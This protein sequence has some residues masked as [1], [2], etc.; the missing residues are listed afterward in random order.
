MKFLSRN[1]DF[2]VME[3]L[4]TKFLFLRALDLGGGGVIQHLKTNFNYIQKL[5]Q[6]GVVRRFFLL[7]QKK[8]LTGVPKML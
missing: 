8:I 3:A 4:L 7:R 2:L 1:K 6:L 5:F